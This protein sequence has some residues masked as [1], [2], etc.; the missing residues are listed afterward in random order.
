MTDR[1]PIACSL[2]AA[3]YPKR[4]GEMAA[5]GEAALVDA[6]TRAGH[7]ELRFAGG[8]GVRERVHRIVAAESEC[9]A[10]LEMTVADEP[11]AVLLT[12]DAPAG[13]DV[14]LEEI[15]AAFRNERVAGR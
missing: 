15:V 2:G 14:V 5:L 7:A 9:C 13:A 12:I 4:L 8:A 6:R 3:G 11:E 1:T 10:F